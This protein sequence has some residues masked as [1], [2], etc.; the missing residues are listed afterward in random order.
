[1][2]K[3]MK[4][5]TSPKRQAGQGMS[6][7]IIITALIAMSAI[8]LVSEFGGVIQQQFAAMAHAMS[9]DTAE[10]PDIEID[11]GKKTDLGSWQD[12]TGGGGG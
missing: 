5:A 12:N 10:K 2:R 11:D 9:G 7:Y 8:G 1:M 4:P 6:E 3:S